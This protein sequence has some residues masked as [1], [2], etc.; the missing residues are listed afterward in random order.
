M[1]VLEARAARP[2]RAVYQWRVCRGDH[3]RPYHDFLIT[4]L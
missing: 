1:A 3:R 4:L 2:Y